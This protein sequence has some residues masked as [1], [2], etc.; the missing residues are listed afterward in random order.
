[1]IHCHKCGSQIVKHNLPNTYNRTTG[2]KR[3]HFRKLCP[4]VIIAFGFIFN[5]GHDIYEPDSQDVLADMPV[6]L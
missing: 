3:E 1:M 5:N 4:K 6:R 2:E